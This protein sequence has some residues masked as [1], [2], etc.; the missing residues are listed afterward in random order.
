MHCE[1]IVLILSTVV[2]GINADS[3]DI[4]PNLG[5]GIRLKGSIFDSISSQTGSLFPVLHCIDSNLQSRQALPVC[6]ASD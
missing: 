1:T 3:D 6:I 4:H 5:L 2:E